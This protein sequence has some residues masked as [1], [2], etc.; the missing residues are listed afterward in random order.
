[1][2]TDDIMYNC[3]AGN[4]VTSCRR[5]KLLQQIFSP[6]LPILQVFH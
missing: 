4:G 6:V 3:T 5:P 2:I 1:M